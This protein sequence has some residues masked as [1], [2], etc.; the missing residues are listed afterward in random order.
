MTDDAKIADWCADSA[1]V[2]KARKQHHCRG[3]WVDGVGRTKCERPIEKGEHYVEYLG[4]TPLW[5]SGQRYH[6]DCARQ[7]HFIE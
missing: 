1:F 2:R 7:Q 4:E 3:G 6:L 5:Q